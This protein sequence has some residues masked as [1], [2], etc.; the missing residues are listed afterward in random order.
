[1][2]ILA[3]SFARRSAETNLSNPAAWFVN[4]F[5]GHDTASGVKVDPV[6]SLRV[7]A[8]FAC[9]RILAETIGSLPLHV[10]RRLPN[11]G[12]ERAPDHPLYDLLHS[13][14]NLEMTSCEWR[15]TAMGHGALRGNAYSQ[16]IF[17]DNGRQAGRPVEIIPLNPDRTRPERDRNTREIFYEYT[18]DQGATRRFRFGEVLHERSLGSN[19]IIGYSPIRMAAEAVGVSLAAEQHG[20]RFFSNGANPTGV[21][22]KTT[23]ELSDTAYERLRKSF[24][25]QYAG[26]ANSRK[27]ILLEDGLTWQGISLNHEQAQFLET[28]KFQVTEI[29]RIFRVPPHMLAD[30]ERATFSNI[31]H[32]SIEFVMHTILPWV[33]R[34][35]QRYNATLLLPS[36][37]AE[38]FCQFSLDGLLRADAKTRAESLQIQ[39]FNGVIN[40]DEWRATENM[41]PYPGGDKYLVQSAMVPLDQIGK[42]PAVEATRAAPPEARS[43]QARLGA[44]LYPVVKASAERALRKELKALRTIAKR[45]DAGA[46]IAQFY[47]EHRTCLAEHLGPAYESLGLAVGRDLAP[48]ARALADTFC[49]E[50]QR[51]AEAAAGDASTLESLLTS[52]EEKRA[53]DL[54]AQAIATLTTEPPTKAAA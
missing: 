44:I 17:G 33:V 25:D 53:G 36:E 29:A 27:P 26:L 11:G 23:G 41:N 9:V 28:R 39:R 47:A 46:A 7:A 6:S 49:S 15:E 38:Y 31:E 54:A 14:P 37:R 42:L 48:Q 1:M 4:L 22:Q 52:W 3:R 32:Q 21:L 43:E 13:A 24:A 40:G 50:Q 18:S 10:Y 20:A 2:S 16:I 30:L 5:G 34:K 12:K 19:G 35:E 45:T 51:L 8:V